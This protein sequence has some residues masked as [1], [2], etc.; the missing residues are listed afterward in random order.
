LGVLTVL[1]GGVS[2]LLK[3]LEFALPKRLVTIVSIEEVL[4]L[5]LELGVFLAL[6]L[7]LFLRED[8]IA[9]ESEL[10]L[11]NRLVEADLLCLRRLGHF[12]QLYLEV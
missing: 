9:G 5:S 3:E 8:L 12:S 1:L 7:K 6:L 4:V 10:E 2:L 11:L